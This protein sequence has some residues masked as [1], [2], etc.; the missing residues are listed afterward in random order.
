[1]LSF[2][3]SACNLTSSNRQGGKNIPFGVTSRF[4]LPND[5]ILFVHVKLT[6][7]A[8]PVSGTVLVDGSSS[9]F[10]FGAVNIFIKVLRTGKKLG[11]YW[12]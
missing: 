2:F 6:F 10:I 7:V 12:P 1:M 3:P 4:V 5:G 8:L 11:I 9:I